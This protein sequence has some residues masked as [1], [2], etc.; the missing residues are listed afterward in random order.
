MTKKNEIVSHRVWR[1]ELLLILIALA[2][3]ASSGWLGDSLKGELLFDGWVQ[4]SNSPHVMF[5]RIVSLVIAAVFACGSGYLLYQKRQQYLPV[6]HLEECKQPGNILA[7]IAT[8]SAPQEDAKLVFSDEGVPWLEFKEP[9]RPLPDSLE[10]ATTVSLHRWNWQQLLRAI[11]PHTASVKEIHLIGSPSATGSSDRL[12]DCEKLIRFYLPD[13]KVCIVSSAIDFENIDLLYHTFEQEIHRLDCAE[14]ETVLDVTGGQ[15]TASIAAALVTL[16]HPELHF[17][18]V[19]QADP[20]K[21]LY[22]NVATARLS[23]I[24]G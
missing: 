8:V 9:A 5:W 13:V 3:V 4:Y 24:E 6:G 21:V 22:Y 19:S 14:R 12:G 11:K 23:D 18:Y 16:H 2:F 20:R 7:L 10:Q 17:Q 15:K 1:R